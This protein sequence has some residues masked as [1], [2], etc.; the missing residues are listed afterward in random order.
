MF[1]EYVYAGHQ[2]QPAAQQNRFGCDLMKITS[3]TRQPANNYV[4]LTGQ[5]FNCQVH[6]T[7]AEF[8]EFLIN[9]KTANRL[10]A[11]FE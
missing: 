3:Y 4:T 6:M 2:T 8:D 7:Q 10:R 9:L 5:G 11:A 1:K